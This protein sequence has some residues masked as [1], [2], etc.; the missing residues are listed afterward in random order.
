[1]PP[2]PIVIDTDIGADPDDA[3]ALALA[4]ASPEFQVLGVTVVDG[5]VGL[6]SRMAA[7]LLGLAG[8]ADV[9]VIP[10]ASR[11]L[12]PGR[13][14]TMLGTEGEGLFDV[15]FAGRD[16]AILDRAADAWLRELARERSYH[17]VA[18]GPLTNVAT[19]IA[20]DPGFGRR[21]LGLSIMGG[22]W[23]EGRLPRG[24]RDDVAARGPAAAWPDHNTA[25]DPAAALATAR[26][27]LAATWVPIEVT[28]RVP[29]RR[30][31]LAALPDTPLVAA[32]RGMSE[33]WAA[34]WFAGTLPPSDDDWSIPGDAVGF[35]HDPLTVAALAPG[36]WLALRA[37]RVDAVVAD[38]VFRLLPAIEGEGGFPA[39]IAIDVDG[40]AFAAFCLGRIATL[41]R[42]S[43]TQTAS[44]T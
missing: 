28:A 39:T 41:A 36:R 24:W 43:G 44:Q 22:V 31:A 11:P 10:G 40:E 13:G 4:L 15:P 16:A 37:V 7:R 32:L 42:S 17:L 18:I 14:P 27:G 5:D 20:R 21:M 6:R 25:S 38:G 34:R 29:L 3:F 2:I 26:S 8:R 30:S 19:A 12:G 9:P 23:D 33:A 35:L 1:M